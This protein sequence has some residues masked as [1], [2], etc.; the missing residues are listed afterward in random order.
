MKQ[1]LYQTPHLTKHQHQRTHTPGSG[2]ASVLCVGRAPVTTPTPAPTSRSTLGRNPTGVASVGSTS[3]RAPAG[4]STTQHI[5][6]S[7]PACVQCGKHF[8]NSSHFSA[9]CRT[10]TGERPY[11]C[12]A[13][14]Q[15]FCQCTEVHKHQRAH[16]GE[17]HPHGYAKRV[18]LL[19]RPLRLQ[20]PGPK[21]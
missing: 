2:H 11:T 16:T 7:G 13:C 1:S 4:S 10:H 17:K 5:P 14:G 19:L 9:H 12:P 18:Q 21:A 15:G 6:G 20:F 8:S 3:A